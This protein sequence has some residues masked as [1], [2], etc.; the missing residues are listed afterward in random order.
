MLSFTQGGW[1][2]ES[3]HGGPVAVKVMH[4]GCDSATELDSLQREVD[5]LSRLQHPRIVRLL[6]ACMAPPTLCLVEELVPGGS[7]HARLHGS[8]NTQ[9]L[10]YREV[11]S[12]VR[13]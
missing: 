6:G 5:V 1:H 8:G 4:A 13:M 11:R 3:W 2:T 10:P 12:P 7:L 9:A